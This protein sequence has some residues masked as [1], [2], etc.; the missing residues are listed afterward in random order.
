MFQVCGRELLVFLLVRIALAR[1][2]PIRFGTTMRPNFQRNEGEVALDCPES[3][4]WA[5]ANG[6]R[7]CE[8]FHAANDYDKYL[9]WYDPE[10]SCYNNNSLSC[11]DNKLCIT[12]KEFMKPDICPN[13]FPIQMKNACCKSIWKKND[14]D[15]DGGRIMDNDD[16]QCCQEGNL[17]QTSACQANKKRCMAPSAFKAPDLCPESHPWAL[18]NG[19]RCCKRFHRINDYNKD[20]DWYDSASLCY[21]DNSIPCKSGKWCSTRTE[22]ISPIEC[23]HTHPVQMKNACCKSYWRKNEGICDGDLIDAGD[24]PACCANEYLFQ[25]ALCQENKRRCVAQVPAI[26]HGELHGQLESLD[27][28]SIWL[29]HNECLT[30]HNRKI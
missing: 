16:P 9:D 26:G 29:P 19:T 8:R 14:G 12:R 5:M 27:V 3:H 20:L 18:A 2:D 24:D 6:T 4:P 13:T 28:H 17:F 21:D 30:D 15:C 10:S 22:V 25:P 23:P 1:S 7:C 11:P